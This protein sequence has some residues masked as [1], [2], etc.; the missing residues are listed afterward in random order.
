MKKKDKD[1]A[2][3]AQAKVEEIKAKRTVKKVK[4][5]ILRFQ[6]VEQ[7][8]H[9]FTQ[10]E[11]N[12]INGQLTRALQLVAEQEAHLQAVS[13]DIKA[14]IKAAKGEVS[15]ALNKSTNGYEIRP[16]EVTI[17]LNRKTGKKRLFYH[18]PGDKKLH[19]K[20]INEVPMG[21]VDWERL[22]LDLPPEKVGKNGA[23]K[24]VEPVS[25]KDAA[26]GAEKDR[27]ESD[28]QPPS[29]EELQEQMKA[30]QIP[31]H[32]SGVPTRAKSF[33]EDEEVKF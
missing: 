32:P 12:E 6:S 13:S 14:R 3:G 26:A 7:L 5:G 25:G 15:V 8:R 31:A 24:P 21:P 27:A 17:E 1:Q 4:S 9:D 23:D 28:L 11:R 10:D 18:V 19:G 20:L 33:G 30:N 16:Q 22:P 2:A 29:A